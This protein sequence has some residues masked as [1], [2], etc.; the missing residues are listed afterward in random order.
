[1]AFGANWPC[2][3]GAIVRSI[4][5]SR[6]CQVHESFRVEQIRGMFDAPCD[7][8][9]SFQ[10]ACNLPDLDDAWTIGCVVGPSGSGK[11]TL[12]RE[13]FG[14]AICHTPR[15]RKDRAVID[16]M[17]P[18]GA[19]DIART[20][21]SVGLGSP[22]SWIK[23]YHALSHGEQLRC[24]L[25]RALQYAR[26][27]RRQL[28]VFDEFASVVDRVTARFGCL[29]LSHAIRRRWSPLKFVAVTSHEDVTTWL[30]P[31][32]TLDL[33]T[34]RLSRQNPAPCST[35]FQFS[36]CQQNIWKE[37][38]PFHYLSGELAR[39]ASCYVALW[40][41]MPAA[42]CASMGVYGSRGRKRITRLVTK[43]VFQGV[44]LGSAL[45]RRVCDLETAAGFQ[46]S[47]ITSHPAMVEHCS[48]SP[49]WRFV[50]VKWGQSASRQMAWGLSVKNSAG[51]SVAV[52]E[53]VAPTEGADHERVS[54]SRTGLSI[55]ISSQALARGLAGLAA[56]EKARSDEENRA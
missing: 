18:E 13:A 19:R 26:T 32:W 29:A 50:G 30:S 1:M 9:V 53:F 34:Q 56:F 12:V 44:G 39:S 37:F 54:T 5:A 24:N 15:W 38:A 20:F 4:S 49:R 10:I 11:S 27:R 25:A 17:G 22:M 3:K 43:P 55:R 28:L 31:D 16:Q 2:S 51:R 52:F 45:L 7:N 36:R 46:V 47:L 42:F 41:G 6:E 48:R 35:E 33:A 40:N 23:P 21:T 14:K 8:R